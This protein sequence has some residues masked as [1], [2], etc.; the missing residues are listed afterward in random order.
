MLKKQYRLCL[1]KDFDNVFKSKKSLKSESLLLKYTNN[2]LTNPRIA[3]VVSNK[4]NKLATKRN[5]IKR[6]LRNISREHISLLPN[7][8]IVI[9]AFKEINTKKYTEVKQ[10]LDN[11]LNKIK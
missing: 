6:I 2:D 5:Y 9:V 7:I 11:L 4:V 10:E 3:F 8:D 1:K